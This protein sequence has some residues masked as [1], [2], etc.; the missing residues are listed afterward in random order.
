MARII[1]SKCLLGSNCR[2]DG[3]SHTYKKIEK[4]KSGNVIIPICPEQMG[5]L[6]TPR[7]PSEIVEDKV[8]MKGGRDVTNEFELG[9]KASLFIAKTCAADFAVLKSLSPSCG[10]GE[11]YSGTFS[12]TK[13]NGNGITAKLLM[14]NGIEVYTENEIDKILEKIKLMQD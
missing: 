8:I 14:D 11:V 4:L 6:P 12:K 2:Y 3:K 5:N 7:N 13:V 9:A 1:I 10:K